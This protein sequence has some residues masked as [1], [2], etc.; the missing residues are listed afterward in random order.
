MMGAYCSPP[1]Q[2]EK[3]LGDEV[4]RCENLRHTVLGLWVGALKSVAF[5]P[6]MGSDIVMPDIFSGR[7]P[8]HP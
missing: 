4:K 7:R 6:D 5:P 3:G 2:V 8:L 1:P